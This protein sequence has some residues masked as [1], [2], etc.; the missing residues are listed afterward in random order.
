MSDD[1]RPCPLCGA[2]ILPHDVEEG[3]CPVCHG[4]LEGL[5]D[6]PPVVEDPQPSSSDPDNQPTS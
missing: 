5:G 1:A 2:S 6:A 4:S 3:R